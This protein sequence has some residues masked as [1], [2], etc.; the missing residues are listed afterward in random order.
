MNT[1]GTGLIRLTDS[2]SNETHPAAVCSKVVYVSDESG[3][4]DLWSMDLDGSSKE[5]LT[6]SEADEYLPAE[7]PLGGIV[8][9]RRSGSG[10]DY[11]LWVMN[12]DGTGK[13]Q[14]TNDPA[15]EVSPVFSP[16]PYQLKVAYALESDD[17]DI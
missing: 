2:P 16:S 5:Q 7:S 11:D 1:D 9:A 10:D 13:T 6:F 15:N 17:S 12:A 4:Y 14:L 3:N 8:Y